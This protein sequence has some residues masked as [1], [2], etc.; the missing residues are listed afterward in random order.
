M[1]V[2]PDS[3]EDDGRER[4]EEKLHRAFPKADPCARLVLLR[5][6]GKA[7]ILTTFHHGICDGFSGVYFLRDLLLAPGQEEPLPPLAPAP[8]LRQPIPDSLRDNRSIQWRLRLEGLP[9]S[10]EKSKRPAKKKTLSILAKADSDE[11]VLQQKYVPAVRSLEAG[12]T[13]VVLDRCHQE[14]GTVHAAV[15]VAWLRAWRCFF[16]D[17]R[18]R[19]FAVSS[20]GQ[21]QASLA[22]PPT[23][24]RRN[25]P[26]RRDHPA[27]I[28][29][30]LLA[31]GARV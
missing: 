12:Q 25:V 16:P 31:N 19:W 6:K 4:V 10:A 7:D 29:G 8:R 30:R 21:P 15:C 1:Q 9:H 20:P 18:K 28:P 23:R 11:T 5:R 17:S 2:Y 26:K 22:A 13:Q 3:Q 24:K 27:K 14:G